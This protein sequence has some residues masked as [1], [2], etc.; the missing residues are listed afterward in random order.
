MAEDIGN[1]CNIAFHNFGWKFKWLKKKKK[2]LNTG[3]DLFQQGEVK[4]NF[5][6]LITVRDETLVYV[7]M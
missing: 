7:Y 2:N 4:K 3:T 1:M 5:T 6:K